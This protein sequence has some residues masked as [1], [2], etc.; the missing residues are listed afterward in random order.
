MGVRHRHVRARAA[1]PVA[2]G[3]GHVT[4][5]GIGEAWSEACGSRPVGFTCREVVAQPGEGRKADTAR[6]SG[7]SK[8]S[9]L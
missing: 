3:V 7:V 1:V 6:V 4:R 2:G 8:Q 5:G 9:E